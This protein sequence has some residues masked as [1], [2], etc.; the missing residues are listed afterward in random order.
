MQAQSEKPS[1]SI[2]KILGFREKRPQHDNYYDV[3]SSVTID[4]SAP[5]YF[6]QKSFD[7]NA[8]NTTFPMKYPAVCPTLLHVD[9][10][11]TFRLK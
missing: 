7:S 11:P 9:A 2:G 3:L 8:K 5:K 6:W 4:D 10:Q 1:R